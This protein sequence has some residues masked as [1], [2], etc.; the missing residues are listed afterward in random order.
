MHAWN[1][2]A[3][4]SYSHDLDVARRPDGPHRRNPAAHPAVRPVAG[5]GARAALPRDPQPR[6]LA[7]VPRLRQR[8][9]RRLGLPSSRR[10]RV[11]PSISA[12][13]PAWRRRAR[14][15]AGTRSPR[16]TVTWNFPARGERPPVELKW[17]DGGLLPPEPVRG[18]KF[19][20]GGG[21]IFYGDKG[22]MCGRVA[23]LDRATA[24][25]SAH[26][27]DARRAAAEDHPAGRRRTAR[28][29]GQRHPPGHALRLGLRLR[30][31]RM[32]RPCCSASRRSAPARGSSGTRPPAA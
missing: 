11:T 7:R 21:S 24:A 12:R 4:T 1:N 6:L 20:V 30:A 13:R 15:R 8:P 14:S 26:A 19:D 28:R 23:Q 22:I 3:S 2:T 16:H 27:G 32:R 9:A 5:G 10:G 18:F 29:V 31:F 17:F 25:G